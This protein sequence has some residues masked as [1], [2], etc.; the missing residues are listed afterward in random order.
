APAEVEPVAERAERGVRAAQGVPD[1]PAHERARGADGEDVVPRVVLA[2]VHLG[3]VDAR[4]AAPEAGRRHPDLDDARGPVPRALL[5]ARDGDRG[6][7]L[8]R[9]HERGERPGLGGG[10]VVEEPEPGVLP[11]GRAPGLALARALALERGP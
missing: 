5:R 2:L 1:V 6:R 11:A 7:D 10:V 8:D 3:L 9:A 4:H